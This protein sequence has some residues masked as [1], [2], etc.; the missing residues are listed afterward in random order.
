MLLSTKCPRCHFAFKVEERFS[1][2]VCACPKP[3][4]AETF[5]L[6]D[7]GDEPPA[8]PTVV[9]GVHIDRLEIVEGPEA[10]EALSATV[11]RL[12]DR[13]TTRKRFERPATGGPPV[14]QLWLLVLAGLFAASGLIAWLSGA[15]YGAETENGEEAESVAAA[16]EFDRVLR[17]FVNDFCIDC[18]GPDEQSAGIA[19]HHYRSEQSVL[20]ARKTWERVLRI[21]SLGAMPPPDHEPRPSQTQRAAIAKWIDAKLH[22]LD[23]DQ[24]NDPGQP[25]IQRLNRAEYDNTIRDLTGLDLRPAATFPSDDVGEGFDN[26]GDVLSLPP[27]L[28]EKY[29]DAAERIA[30]AL[31]VLD[32]PRPVRQRRNIADLDRTSSVE[33]QGRGFLEIVDDGSVTATFPFPI[34]GDY[35]I[36]I[37]SIAEQQGDDSVRMGVFLDDESVAEKEIRRD[38]R[39]NIE[40]IELDVVEGVHALRIELLNPYEKRGKQRRL[41]IRAVEINGPL[42][43]GGKATSSTHERIIFVHPDEDRTAR[44]CARQ[45]LGRFAS[46]AFRRPIRR[47]KLD[48]LVELVVS[49][50]DSHNES[51]EQAIHSALQAVLV[52]SEFLFRVEQP[53]TS[54]EGATSARVDDFDLAS[55]LSYFLWSS[56]PDDELQ[57]LAAEGRLQQDNTL[58]AQVTRL[59]SD[60]RSRALV[61]NFASQWLNLRNLEDVR[62]D[63]R[64]FRSWTPALGLDM[65]RETEMVFET[66]M[67][68]DRSIMEFLDAD[69]T[70]VNQ[71][72]ARHYDIEDVVGDGFQRVSLLETPRRGILTHA[73][74]LTLTSY[75]TRTSPVIR[76]KWVME[77]ILG[78]A[79]PPPPEDVPEL[80]ETAR[81]NRRLSLREQLALHR[82]D[83]GCATCHITMDAIGFGFENFDAIGRWRDRDGRFAIDASGELPDGSTFAGPIELIAILRT[84][85]EQFCETLVRRMLVYAL[86]RGL[87]Y[88]DQCV[89]NDVIDELKRHD[90]RFS[91]LVNGIVQSDAF[92]NRR[93]VSNE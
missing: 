10:D 64:R 83:P 76:G 37:E 4:C 41:G 28:L 43:F 17:P 1:G 61:D 6:P 63:R 7:V 51:F 57:A 48:R 40:S 58:S 21:V 72:L 32:Q 24:I 60:E 30:D 8:D 3:E 54:S 73:A 80:E 85:R 66:I 38:K 5:R 23:C 71:R 29:L 75:P 86:G 77:N 91:A 31:V 50:M 22:H 82:E 9:S 74:V 90:F 46:Q 70:F 59:I 79:P 34:S 55:R 62:P 52:S 16:E 39:E 19:F 56:M 20:D 88:Y 18:H 81:S 68:E 65:R 35:E 87:E 47:P 78:T 33:S 53:V 25:T 36:R 49:R 45:I 69:F 15:A 89:V 67:R 93:A 12:K 84:R 44:D 13:Q 26:I 42:K 27:L 11:S 14:W 92:R 2:H